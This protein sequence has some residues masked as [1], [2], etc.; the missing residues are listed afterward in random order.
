MLLTIDAGNTH[1]HLGLYQG[2]S[3]AHTWRLHTV[4]EQTADEL[5]VLV[6]GLLRAERLEVG[7]L[8]GCAISCVVPPLAP[9]LREFSRRYLRREPELLGENLEVG[10]PIRYDSPQTVGA[11]R[12]A[13]ALCVR[14]K[15]GA[16]AIIVDFG[17]ATTYDA[18]SAAGE[19]LGGAILP[20]IGLCAE[21]L[22]R[23]VPHLPRVGVE[24]PAGIIGSSTVEGMRSGAYYGTIAQV[25]G[26]VR[27]F[28]AELGQGTQAIATGGL[29]A[30]IAEDAACFDHLDPHLTLEGLRRAWERQ[31][32]AGE[33]GGRE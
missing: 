13:D 32:S 31:H 10:I 19:Y 17:T 3:L 27:R 16:P 11:D 4:R 6:L 28:R 29:A 15:Y 1:L 24:K 22:A 30:L 20:G 33:Q 18:L 26:M 14:E 2:S 5:G 7:E 8:Q 25:E 23:V 9:A 21:A 12:L